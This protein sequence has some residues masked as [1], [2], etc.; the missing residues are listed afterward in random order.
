MIFKHTSGPKIK[1]KHQSAIYIS[2]KKTR[3]RRKAARRSLDVV[4]LLHACDQ[5]VMVVRR[6][7]KRDGSGNDVTVGVAS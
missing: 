2:V 1:R 3:F 7:I 6:Y 5:S 4:G